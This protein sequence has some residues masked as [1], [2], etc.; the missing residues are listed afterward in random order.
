MNLKNNSDIG[1]NW[2]N[3]RLTNN[4]SVI[5]INYKINNSSS[6]NRRTVV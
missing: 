3:T 4:D 2:E 1:K 5:C 6:N